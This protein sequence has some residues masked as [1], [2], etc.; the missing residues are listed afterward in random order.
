[1]MKGAAAGQN[2]SKKIGVKLKRASGLSREVVQICKWENSWKSD[3]T[4][5]CHSYLTM[6]SISPSRRTCSRFFCPVCYTFAS[7]HFTKI[8]KHIH[9]VHSFH[10]NFSVVFRISGCPRTYTNFLSYKKHIYR[11]HRNECHLGLERQIATMQSDV[12]DELA[13][14]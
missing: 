6:S 4:Y 14:L 2:P 1:M 10:S 9:H 5:R 13:M 12:S 11:S 8:M 7:I 3:H